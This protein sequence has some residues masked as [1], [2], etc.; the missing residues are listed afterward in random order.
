MRVCVCACV[1][2]CVCVC[3][4]ACACVVQLYHE[5]VIINLLETTLY[6]SD[7][8][9]SADDAITDFIDFLHRKLAYLASRYYVLQCAPCGADVQL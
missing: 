6:H 8:C 9:E 3:V 1:C 4:R 5:A 2:V 7:A